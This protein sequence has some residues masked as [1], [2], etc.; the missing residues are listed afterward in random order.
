MVV[1]R[2]RMIISNIYKSLLRSTG[3]LLEE[4]KSTIGH[5][6]IQYWSWESRA[7]EN[8]LPRMTLIGLDAFTFEENQGLWLVRYSIGLSSY[9]D[10]H[11]LRE[12]EIL[13]IIHDRTGEGKKLK[14][15]DG[16][17]G[18]EL[19]E[20]V[21]TAWHLSPMSQSELRNYRTV[22]IELLRTGVS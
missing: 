17:T 2:R 21:T 22:S 10:A 12:M 19:S 20:M 6:D 3:D 7:Q 14:L 5:Q 13:N 8:E 18:A 9:Q 16:T 11:L 15:L 4:I 1:Y